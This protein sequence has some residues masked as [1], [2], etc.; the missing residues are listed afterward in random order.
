MAFL[1]GADETRRSHRGRTAGEST[2]MFHL[3]SGAELI[4]L[5]RQPWFRV[6]RVKERGAALRR[7][8]L[9]LQGG[10]P[11]EPDREVITAGI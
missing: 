1:E 11:A 2:G 6:H 8:L 7:P 5:L 9:H 3:H 10:A 4:E